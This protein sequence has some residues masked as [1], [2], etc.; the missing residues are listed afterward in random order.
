MGQMQSSAH[1]KEWYGAYIREAMRQ[2]RGEAR[3]L[4]VFCVFDFRKQERY[5][6]GIFGSSRRSFAELEMKDQHIRAGSPGLNPAGK[7]VRLEC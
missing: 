6:S 2:G 3:S 1:Q 7:W 5:I 4:S